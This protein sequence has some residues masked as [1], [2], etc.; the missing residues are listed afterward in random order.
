ME[1]SVLAEKRRSIRRYTNERIS[2]E[3]IEEIISFAQKAPS[4]KNS[5]TGRYYVALSDEAINVV[6]EALPEF[7]RRSSNGAAYIVSSFKKD[8]SG[9]LK[10]NEM[11]KEGNLWGSYD[12][13]LQNCYLLLKAAE[14]GYDTLIMGIRDDE[15]LRAYFGIPE[16][17]II[18]PVIAIGKRD[19]EPNRMVRKELSEIL[20]VR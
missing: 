1:L 6:Y 19:I 8:L 2:K 9:A 4:W 7:N 16:D 11:S 14:M 18:L 10:E 20:K 15:A 3:A 17:E 12:L 13:G 5:Q